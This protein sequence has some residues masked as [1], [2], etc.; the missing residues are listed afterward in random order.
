MNDDVMRW[1]VRTSPSRHLSDYLASRYRK[2]V[3]PVWRWVDCSIADQSFHLKVNTGEVHGYLCYMYGVIEP[4]LTFFIRHLLPSKRFFLD[5]GANVGYYSVLAALVNPGCR[6]HSFEPSPSTF[7]VLHENVTANHLLNVQTNQLALGDKTGTL[8][9]NVYAD[10][11]L[12]SPKAGDDDQHPFFKEG[13]AQVIDVPSIKL[14]DFLAEHHLPQPDVVKLDVEGFEYFV[15]Q[16]ARNLLSS[17]NPPILLCEVE[18]LWLKRFG[19]VSSDLIEYLEKLSYRAFVLTRYGLVRKDEISRY[20]SGD[21]V[22]VQAN[23]LKEI[24]EINRKFYAGRRR[25]KGEIKK[26]LRHMWK[27]LKA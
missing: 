11:A 12:N 19:L 15:L 16:G 14:D 24:L 18:P 21:M 8:K 26:I 4:E 3:T 2:N 9:F 1:V 7:G 6:I 13:P 5:I 20:L 23:G 27:W 25:F 10:Q 17:A 22:F